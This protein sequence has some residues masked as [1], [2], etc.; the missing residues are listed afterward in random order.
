MTSVD[1]LTTR[2]SFK[3]KLIIT[4]ILGLIAT[5]IIRL[6]SSNYS[7]VFGHQQCLEGKV[8]LVK[9][10]VTPSKGDYICLKGTHVPLYEKIK[11]VKLVKGI[12][13]DLVRVVP[14]MSGTTMKVMINNM[15]IHLKV[16]AR[17]QLVDSKNSNEIIAEYPVFEKGISGKELPFVLGYGTTVIKNGYFVAGTH[18]ASYDSRYWGIVDKKDVIGKAV[19]IF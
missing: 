4:I 19:L 6:F 14:D 3:T 5:G 9:K 17:V 10:K 11:L 1:G 12:E 18:P 13:G 7:I 15:P 2:T 8:W 16:R